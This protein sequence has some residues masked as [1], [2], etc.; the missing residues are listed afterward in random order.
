MRPL[1]L[2]LLIFLPIIMEAQAQLHTRNVE[3]LSED[4]LWFEG[5]IF[6]ANGREING[7]IKYNDREGFVAYND[8]DNKKVFTANSILKFDFYDEQQRKQRL[9]LVLPFIDP[10]TGGER[11][12]IFEIIR[13]YDDFAILLKKDPLNAHRR[14]TS[15]GYDYLIT[16]DT[17][18]NTRTEVSQVE[19]ILFLGTDGTINPYVTVKHREDSRKSLITMKDRKSKSKTVV[20]EDLLAQYVTEPVYEK[21]KVYAEEN[22]LK[23]KIIEDFLQILDYYDTIKK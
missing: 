9:F 17:R 18:T 13:E 22:D 4:Q 3:L 5:N 21:L 23:F 8:G 2:S 19:S 11:S 14:T 20:D 10:K 12:Q 7:L 16:D 15:I 6:L 1:L